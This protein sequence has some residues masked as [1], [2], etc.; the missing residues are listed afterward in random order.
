MSGM[1]AMQE[2]VAFE[3]TRA[4]RWELETTHH[5]FRPLTPIIRDAYVRAFEDGLRVPV[6]DY[7]LPLDGVRGQLL[8]GCLYVRPQGLGEGDKPQPMPPKFVMKVLTRVHPGMRRRNRAAKEAWETKRWR[9]EVDQWF[10]VDRVALIDK[11]L[12][13]QSVELVALDDAALAAEVDRLLAHFETNARRNL[14]T[15]G[16]D[17]MPTGDLL[18]HC[19]RWGISPA[20]AMALLQGS[21]PATVETAQLLSPVAHALAACDEAPS[22]IE[23][24]SSLGD[25]VRNAIGQWERMHAWRT[26]TSDDVDRPTLAELPALRL[27]ALRA[28][29]D[30][31]G[32][33]PI[34]AED[35]ERLRSR[36]PAAD[37]PLFDEL[38]TEAR[39]G[40]RQR[41]DIRGICW[42]W[43]GGL[44]RRSL[45]EVGRRL[46]QRGGA[47]S[48]D[49]AVELFPGEL[50]EVLVNGSGPNAAE[51]AE[52]A[53]RRDQIEAIPPPRFLGDVE[54]APPLDALPAPMAR[55]TAALMVNLENDVTSL[56]A[57]DLC[58]VGIGAGVYRG[59]ACV[60]RDAADASERLQPGDVMIAT[61]T[62][63]SFNSVLPMLGALVVE[64]G[65]AM[66]HAAIVAREFGVPAVIGAQGAVALIA[67][68]T[69]VE[70][71]PRA[72]VIRVL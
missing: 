25:D 35:E 8:H 1:A 61:F 7:G 62:G 54:E 36:V 15:H 11:N 48:V 33:G 45:L 52:R 40:H 37:R 72:G 34:P 13:L 19:E 51:L 53:E 21:S 4:G 63:P 42:N 49:H 16:G 20:E 5:G 29:I 24:M 71:D 27:A 9:A 43:T 39:Y 65:G 32:L 44:L 31:R 28:S 68:G 58:G 47:V 67:D 64:E 3:S 59:R 50:T 26:V 55:A 10:D 30:H 56:D 6:A 38:V 57:D 70:V 69:E 66:C 17:L 18:A 41:E 14:A 2:K 60:V 46:V 22:S 23:A 12:Q